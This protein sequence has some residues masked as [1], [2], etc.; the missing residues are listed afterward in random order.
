MTKLGSDIDIKSKSISHHEEL[1][2]FEIR[3]SELISCTDG[4]RKEMN[5]K[6]FPVA[7]TLSGVCKIEIKTR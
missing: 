4:N 5:A 6:I 1:V 3:V 2:Q 7:N